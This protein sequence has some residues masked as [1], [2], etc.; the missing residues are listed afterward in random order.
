MGNNA[1]RFE[2]KCPDYTEYFHMTEI[3][4]KIGRS[5]NLWLTAKEAVSHDEKTKKTLKE[6]PLE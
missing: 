5:F 2:V 1:N 6:S 4:R 3:G